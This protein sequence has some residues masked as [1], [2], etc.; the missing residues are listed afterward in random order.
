LEITKEKRKGRE[1]EREREGKREGEER[2]NPLRNPG[3]PSERGAETD[4]SSNR[5]GFING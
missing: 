1:R 3:I 4:L 2:L 5:G